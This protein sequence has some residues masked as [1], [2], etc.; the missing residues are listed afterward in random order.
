VREQIGA[1]NAEV[2][3]EVA[4]LESELDP[5]T[6][7]IETVAVKPRKA[8]LAVEDMALVWVP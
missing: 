5:G 4:R 6:V 3:A 1:L 7:A 8:D 2:E